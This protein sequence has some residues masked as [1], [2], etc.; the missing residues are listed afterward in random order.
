MPVG[1]CSPC[2]I[3]AAA[4]GEGMGGCAVPRRSLLRGCL[5]ASATLRTHALRADDEQDP[6]RLKLPQPGDQLVEVGK[7]PDA[8]PLA[9]GDIE[10]QNLVLAWAFDPHKKVMRDASRLNMVILM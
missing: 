7:G 2:H 1:S 4:Q 10:L 9:P 6:D 8:R 3:V 5:V